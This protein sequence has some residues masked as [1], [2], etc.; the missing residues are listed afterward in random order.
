VAAEIHTDFPERFQERRRVFAL[1]PDGR[2]RELQVE[3]AWTHK[4]RIILKF[5]GVESISQAE[6]LAGAEIQIPRRERAELEPG[7]AYVS[8]LVGSTVFVVEGAGTGA[9]SE[10]ELGQIAEVLFGAGEAPLLVVRDHGP[11][12]KEYLIPY[13]GPYLRTVDIPARRMV[14]SLPEG[15]LET[16]AP[17]SREEKLR[18]H[19]KQ[20]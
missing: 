17:L 14:L 2:R 3:D 1:T 7:A 19:R 13:A 12:A 9:E 10:R 16:D 8:D 5:A 4:D 20:G 6:E 15:M 11:G 18:Q